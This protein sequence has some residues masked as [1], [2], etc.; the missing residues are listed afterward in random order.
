VGQTLAAVGAGNS[1]GEFQKEFFDKQEEDDCAIGS[2]KR[3]VS[4]SAGSPDGAAEKEAHMIL[5]LFIFTLA[6]A[7][8]AQ[9]RVKRAYARHPVFQH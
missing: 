1:A 8:R 7:L 5:V 4:A 9:W 2:A 6:I 3:R